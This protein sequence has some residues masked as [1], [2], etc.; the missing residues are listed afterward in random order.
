M[1]NL[2]MM[3]FFFHV[4]TEVEVTKIAK[5]TAKIYQCICKD[6]ILSIRIYISATWLQD[7]LCS[8]I[9]YPIN[10]ADE[11]HSMRLKASIGTYVNW[12][13]THSLDSIRKHEI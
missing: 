4:E 7:L 9:I 3:N 13:L 12:I 2:C 6:S 1:D 10:K 8:T 5:N 11:L